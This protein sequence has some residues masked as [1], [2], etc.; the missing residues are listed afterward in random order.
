MTSAT[1]AP[2]PTV[3]GRLRLVFDPRGADRKAAVECEADV[4]L[5][6]FGDGAELLE[7]CFGPHEADTT[8][9]ALID[10]AGV[11]VA[12]ARL[13]VPGA[14]PTKYEVYLAEEPWFADPARLMGDARLNRATTWDVASISVRRRSHAQ[15]ALWTAALCHGLFQVAKV[16]EVTATVAVLDE[17][18]RQL[19]ARHGIVYSTLP[20]TWT[21]EFC[22]S[23]AST[24]VYADMRAMVAHQRRA[25]PEAHR[26]VTMGLGLD[27]IDVPDLDGFRLHGREVDLRLRDSAYDVSGL[28]AS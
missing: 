25:F 1:V 5:D 2:S 18:A 22:G 24:P 13:V 3:S 16:N 20:G 17:G 4:F 11:A 14:A 21:A 12:S 8:W 6:R 19:L 10:D 23:P 26:L 9:L 7:E 15:G 27:G 28:L